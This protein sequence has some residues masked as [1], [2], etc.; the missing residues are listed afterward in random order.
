MFEAKVWVFYCGGLMRI[1]LTQRTQRFIVDLFN[2]K[3]AKFYRKGR[4]GFSQ[5][6]RRVLQKVVFYSSSFAATSN[7]SSMIFLNTCLG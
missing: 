2:A 5:R 4:R 3:G 7:F 1:F 6:M